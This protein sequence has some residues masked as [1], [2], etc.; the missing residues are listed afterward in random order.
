MLRFRSMPRV[1]ASF[2]LMIALPAL[3][4]SQ[5]VLRD[6]SPSDTTMRVNV[7]TIASGF[8][9]PVDVAF[10]D[11][12]TGR[13]FVVDQAGQIFVVES[14]G[15]TLP[16][17]FLDLT[18]R[19][20]SLGA[21]DERG[22]LSIALHPQFATNRRFYVSYNAPRDADDPSGFNSELRISEFRVLAEDA[23]RADIDSENVL[24]DI[25]KPSSNHNGGQ[26]AFGPDDMLYV[27][28]GDGGGNGLVGDEGTIPGG[29]A[30]SLTTLLGKVLRIN[31][32]LGAPFNI[33]NDN[34][35]TGVAGARGEIYALGFRNPWRFSFD[36]GGDRR[37]FVGDVGQNLYEEIDIVEA[38]GNYGWIVREGAHCYDAANRT[39]PPASC[40]TTD[41]RGNNFIDPII[42]QP[43]VDEDGNAVG[44]SIIG[45]FVYRGDSIPDLTS[46][47]VFGQWTSQFGATDGR[48][49]AA[50]EDSNGNW[51]TQEL[52]IA[53]S[54]DGRLGRYV[55]AF[56]QGLDGELY[57]LTSESSGP[58]GTTGRVEKIV[59]A[60]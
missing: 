6:R 57:V 17:A 4:A 8:A 38:G 10:P 55:L 21:R 42:E 53:D 2:L 59:I 33:P 37:L 13:M 41:A 1:I 7:Q 54:S 30:Q 46:D 28:V 22:L 34:P 9:S 51:T 14:N 29:T 56:G 58:N 18:D 31:P 15:V 44:I 40:D 3:L 11:D 48:L 60:P 20:V 23:N 5:C 16:T 35:F 47:Y 25:N 27:S 39:N 32:N 45:G 26:L 49:F 19:M 12:G 36:S 43:Q 24:L 52:T 50:S